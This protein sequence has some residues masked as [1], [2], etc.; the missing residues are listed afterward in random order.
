[1]SQSQV[2]ATALLC[3]LIERA[4]TSVNGQPVRD[5]GNAVAL[6]Q[7]ERLVVFGKPLRWVTCPECGMEIARVSREATA[8]QIALH[9]PECGDVTAPRHLR[10]THK[11]ALQRFIPTLLNGLGLPTNGL[12]LIDLDRIWRLGTIEE[13]RGRPVTWYFARC[14]HRPEVASRLRTQIALDRTIQS[15]V[16][17]TSSELP[18]PAASALSEFDVRSLT[19]IGRVGQS[20]FEFFSQR[21]A[22]LG[23]QVL[24]EA[25]PGTTLRYVRDK[26]VVFIDGT[27]YPLEPRQQ[28]I[29][30]ALIDDL[31]HELDKEALKT[32]CASQAQRFSPS[33]VFERNPAGYKTFIRYLRDDERYAL[34]VPSADHDWLR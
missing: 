15:C 33:K 9:C 27:E 22:A 25:V 14:L 1:M 7:R 16:V 23:P 12:R 34:V 26:A 11:V 4:S 18:L 24:E 19:L 17:L 3:R 32:A 6:L 8:D 13:K 2:D 30:V 31:D 29:L 5:G 10:E 21:M 28:S 20:R